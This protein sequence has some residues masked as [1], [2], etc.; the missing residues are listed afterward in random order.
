MQT[1]LDS[2]IEACRAMMAPPQGDIK[3][4]DLTA[5]VD[6]IDAWFKSMNLGELSKAALH[7]LVHFAIDELIPWL[8]AQGPFQAIAAG[9]SESLLREIDKRFH[10]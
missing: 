5:I 1:E 8:K 4:M 2:K 3:T 9:I 10:D 6:K 7:S